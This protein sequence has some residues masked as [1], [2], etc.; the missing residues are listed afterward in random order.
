MVTGHFLVRRMDRARARPCV[1]GDHVRCGPVPSGQDTGED[2]QPRLRQLEYSSADVHGCWQ[3]LQR[4]PLLPLCEGFGGFT[5][6]GVDEGSSV[7]R[8]AGSPHLARN[9]RAEADRRSSLLCQARSW[10]RRGPTATQRK[11]GVA[12]ASAR[13]VVVGADSDLVKVD[14][15]ALAP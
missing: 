12:R 9:A 6:I 11:R 8:S 5:S 3:H 15:P 13:R 10:K 14:V 7:E 1:A 4:P 2:L